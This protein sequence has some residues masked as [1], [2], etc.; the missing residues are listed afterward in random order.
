MNSS[1]LGVSRA[2]SL[3]IDTAL[4]QSIQ[5]AVGGWRL[6]CRDWRLC[7]PGLRASITPSPPLCWSSSTEKA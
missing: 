2:V 5:A 4:W 6:S 7:R 3:S 1:S